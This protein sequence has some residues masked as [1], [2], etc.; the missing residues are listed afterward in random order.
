MSPR[1]KNFSDLVKNIFSWP[2]NL[3]FLEPLQKDSE[4]LLLGFSPLV[5]ALSLGDYEA[6]I[7]KY[8]G[9][10]SYLKAHL[11]I[12]QNPKIL[13]PWA[14]SAFC[15]ALPYPEERSSSLKKGLKISA[16]ALGLDYHSHFQKVLASWAEI[17]RKNFPSDQFAIVT[18]SKPVLERDLAHR[19]GLGFFGKNTMLIHPRRGS[20]FL[21][22]EILTSLKLPPPTEDVFPDL[23]GHCSACLDACPTRAFVKP[24][25]LD[26]T[27]CISY[28]TIEAKDT[29]PADLR[30]DFGNHFFGCD[31]CQDV[32]P[33]N[34]K[35]LVSKTNPSRAEQI[36]SL[37]W[38]LQSSNK[39][40]AN[41]FEGSALLRP[42]PLGLRRNALVVIGN[43]RFHELEPEVRMFLNHK[44]LGELAHW[45]LDLIARG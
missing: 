14:E 25:V 35:F 9:Q 31:I 34:K 8:S 28:W 5:P 30:Q 4:V 17:L 24:R 13:W 29:A 21:L 2:E 6:W 40:L 22:A 36:D 37:R 18:D 44:K 41:A 39:V 1:P 45:T 32:C 16:Y 23:C 27:R 7:E 19:A 33:W 42:R 11:P 12:K 10:M 3:K 43:S 15:F 20:Y 38:I 26:A